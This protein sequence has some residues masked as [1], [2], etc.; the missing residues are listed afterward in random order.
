VKVGFWNV[1]GIGNKDEEFWRGIEIWEVVMMSETWAEGKGWEKIKGKLPK[2]YSW[3]VQLA[4]RRNKRGRAMGGMLM[5]V[6]GGI[7]IIKREEEEGIMMRVIRLKGG[8]IWRV[9]G[10]YINN[11]EEKW[12]KL[13]EWIEGRERGGQ[14][15][16]GGDFNARTEELGG[17]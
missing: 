7:E 13:R 2:G 6:R 4:R 12:G 9:V 11:V 10:V 8:E 3:E 16:I 5:G 1:S 15:I 14:M 17:W